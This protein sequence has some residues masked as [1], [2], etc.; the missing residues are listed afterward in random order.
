MWINTLSYIKN[1]LVRVS[2]CCLVD[3]SCC[4]RNINA[5]KSEAIAECI[6]ADACNCLR[7]NNTLELRIVE[8]WKNADWLK[9]ASFF[10]LNFCH[11][12]S[13]AECV[14]TYSCNVLADNNLL[15]EIVCCV[16]GLLVM[17][18]KVR[19]CACT[20]DPK[21]TVL[22]SCP[23]NCI[24]ELTACYRNV[25]KFTC[26]I[27]NTVCYCKL[28]CINTFSNIKNNLVWI[29]KC[30]LV[31]EACCL[32]NVNTFKCE[33]ITEC[34]SADACYCF[35]KNDALEL[36]IV[37]EWKNANW[38]NLAAF[39]KFNS[40]YIL[41]IAECI[42]T[43]CCNILADNDLLDKVICCVPGLILVRSEVRHCAC[44]CD[45]EFT[46]LVS[47][48]FNCI[49]ELTACNGDINEVTYFILNAVCYC[50]LV[51]IGAVRNIKN[52]ILWICKCS[53]IDESY[54]LRNINAFKGEAITECIRIDVLHSFRKND[55]CQLR[56]IEEWKHTNSVKLA[57][58]FKFN[59]WNVLCVAECI[60]TN[61]CDILTNNDLLDHII[62]WIP[63]LACMRSE[64]RH[65][66]CTVD[67]QCTVWIEF[68]CDIS[69]EATG[70]DNL[71][72][73]CTEFKLMV[74][75]LSIHMTNRI[76]CNL[77]NNV[78]ISCLEDSAFHCYNILRD[79]NRF[80]SDIVI[81]CSLSDCLKLASFFKCNALKSTT[82]IESVAF[83]NFNACRNFNIS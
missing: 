34:I 42:V 13:V 47:C 39:F 53:L 59:Y 58:C 12:L 3:K 50:K 30:C 81:E 79:V 57:A 38:L 15:D 37:E 64:V 54:T 11:V 23:F 25:N 24:A 44:T 18:S 46:V 45:P 49:A 56:I 40:C 14:V 66:A 52:N 65:C 8:E 48:P 51:C 82:F 71:Y 55:A 36:R 26:F 9:L 77:K 80:K 27:L 20:C 69:I 62:E 17:R 29:Y 70:L 74:V 21:L 61:R 1:N 83:D 10:E 78:S 35:R 22:I 67:C 2:K 76:F 73:T 33:A 31:D 4:L 6:S 75:L 43:N 60:V 7:K 68:P 16:P 28:V 72:C 63:R 32:R 41:S 19:H 5:F